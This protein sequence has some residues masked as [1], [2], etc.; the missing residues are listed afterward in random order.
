MSIYD[1]YIDLIFSSLPSHWEPPT[2]VSLESYIRQDK[3]G[4]SV[5]TRQQSNFDSLLFEF[6]IGKK[7]AR[8]AQTTFVL[9]DGG[10][11]KSTLAR[12]LARK[13]HAAGKLLLW[14]D[15]ND[16]KQIIKIANSGQN[17]VEK[18]GTYIE[19][20]K[21]EYDKKRKDVEGLDNE[22]DTLE[23]NLKNFDE[24]KVELEVMIDTNQKM[25][26]KIVAFENIKK[27]T[28]FKDDSEKEIEEL[29]EKE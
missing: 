10:T 21:K 4:L 2:L 18:L 8:K 14:L 27:F 20:L 6:G 16:A 13:A 22:F 15:A 9:G 1:N 3:S 17:L 25:I 19:A 7:S 12:Y 26:E 29:E 5:A 11:G 24:V 28:E 23:S